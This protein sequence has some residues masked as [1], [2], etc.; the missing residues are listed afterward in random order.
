MDKQCHFFVAKVVRV[1]LCLV[2]FY[3]WEVSLL[4]LRV[5]APLVT[6][7][8]GFSKMFVD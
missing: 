2:C 4:D 1:S 7:L 3:R 6:A 8:F 5:A